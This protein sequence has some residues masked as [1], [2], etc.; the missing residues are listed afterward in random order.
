MP[1][2]KR[3]EDRIREISTP[4]LW[5]PLL[6]SRS[7]TSYQ[8][9]V[10]CALQWK[11]QIGDEAWSELVKDAYAVAENPIVKDRNCKDYLESHSTCTVSCLDLLGVLEGQPPKI[12]LV[13]VLPEMGKNP[14]PYKVSLNGGTFKFELLKIPTT[15][16]EGCLCG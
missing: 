14:V 3:M 7:N 16:K 4:R 11:R 5:V 13:T 1:L 6:L 8:N 15:A 12:R 10:T 2:L 9:G